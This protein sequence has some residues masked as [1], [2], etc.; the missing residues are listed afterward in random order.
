MVRTNIFFC[1][2]STMVVIKFSYL[3]FAVS[4]LVFAEPNHRRTL[5]GK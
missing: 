4:T 2:P 5:S 3:L 1:L